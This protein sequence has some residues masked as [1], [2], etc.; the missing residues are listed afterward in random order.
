[1]MSEILSERGWNTYIVGKW[2]LTPTDEMNLAS[3]Q[4]GQRRRRPGRVG[5]RK[6]SLQRHPR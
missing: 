3:T 5:Q 6:P 1:M 2:H 4:W